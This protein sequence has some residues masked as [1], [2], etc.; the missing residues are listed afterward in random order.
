MVWNV[1]DGG[2][3]RILD[4]VVGCIFG[5]FLDL[6]GV[7][8]CHKYG[9]PLSKEGSGVAGGGGCCVSEQ[10]EKW[11]LAVVTMEEREKKG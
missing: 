9:K 8:S 3:I 6:H 1:N 2:S 11:P 4:T 7:V 10:S 5:Q